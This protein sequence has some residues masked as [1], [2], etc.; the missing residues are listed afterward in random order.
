MAA[1]AQVITVLQVL[2]ATEGGTRRHLRDL[3]G[4]L[5]PE[6]FR[7]RLAVSFERGS[8]FR[9]DLAGYAARGVP[10]HEV[11]MRR[12]IAPFADLLS[13]TRLT[14]LVRRTRPDV[15]HAHS[16]KAGFLARL[17]GLWCRVPV[18]YTP[19]VFPFMMEC[20][21]LP[22]CFYRLL[23]RSV[24][25]MT[26][27]LIAVSEEEVRE[28]LRLGYAGERVTLIRNGVAS[29]ELGA[30]TA[31]AAGELKVAFFGR[32]TRQKGPDILIDAAADVVSHVPQVMFLIYGDGEWSEKARAQVAALQRATHVRFKGEYSQDEAV[33]RM[34]EA[35]VV[36]VPSRWEGCPY[37]VLEAFQAGVP[38]VAAAVGGVPELIRD[39]VNGVL[40]EADSAESLC[41]G[42]LSLLRA[43]DKRRRLAEAGRLTVAAHTLATMAAEVG[44]VYR[45]VANPQRQ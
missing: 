43:S 32:L 23:E 38:V 34:R 40:V 1:G 29:V 21:R 28:A 31:R 18:V 27:A 45:R 11:P 35:D 9:E 15:I 24:R 5:D 44:R 22:S 19:H 42:V 13:L 26:A 10:V 20:G 33:T 14:C 7:V 25:G 17:A 6:T 41:A 4:A 37:V 8:A 39:G 2:E 30:V 3:A 12:G 16:A 36:V